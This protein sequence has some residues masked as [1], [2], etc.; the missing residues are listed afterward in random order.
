[1]DLNTQIVPYVSGEKSELEVMRNALQAV[2]I[3]AKSR[4]PLAVGVSQSSLA[5][6]R[7]DAPRYDYHRD[8]AIRRGDGLDSA[9]LTL[10][11]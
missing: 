2:C 6:S 8:Y 10:R 3:R 9:L 4:E 11:R 5:K 1:M 7:H